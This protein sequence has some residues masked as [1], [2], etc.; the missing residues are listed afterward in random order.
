M[1]PKNIKSR[2]A[3]PAAVFSTKQE[4]DDIVRPTFEALARQ[5]INPPIQQSTNPP[6]PR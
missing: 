6:S 2:I 5:P 3:V 1:R 4:W